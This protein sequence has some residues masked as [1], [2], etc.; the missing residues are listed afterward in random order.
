M[1]RGLKDTFSEAA[2][3]RLQQCMPPG[4]PYAFTYDDLTNVN[5]MVNNG[6][7]AGIIDWEGSGYLP[8]WWEYVCTSGVDSEE[9]IEWKKLLRKSTESKGIDLDKT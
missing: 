2:R 1:E 9:D 6:S 7:L 4:T 3:A 5:T 8:V